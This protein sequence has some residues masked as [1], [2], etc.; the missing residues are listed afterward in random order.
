MY[1]GRATKSIRS[2]ISRHKSDPNKPFTHFSVF[3]VTG[4]DTTARKRQICD[5]EALLLN[6]IKPRP[7]WN[8]SVTH[9]VAAPKLKAKELRTKVKRMQY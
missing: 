5:L 2:R 9:F 1:V 3:L 7:K 4:S 6:I 8:S